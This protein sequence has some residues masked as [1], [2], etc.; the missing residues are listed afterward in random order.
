M[1]PDPARR[2][3]AHAFGAERGGRPDDLGRNHAVVQDLLVV[4]YIVD[5]QVERLDPLS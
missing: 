2:V 1:A 5:E 4:V 3:D